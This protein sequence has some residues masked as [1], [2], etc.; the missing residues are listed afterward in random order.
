VFPLWA[1]SIVTVAILFM[2]IPRLALGSVIFE[3]D[4][5][6]EVFLAVAFLIFGANVA[7]ASQESRLAEAC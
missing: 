3:M 1:A 6:G 4:E 2:V 7:S 5:L